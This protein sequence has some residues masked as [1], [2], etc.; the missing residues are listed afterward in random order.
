MN[1]WPCG[2]QHNHDTISFPGQLLEYVL[3]LRI[4]DEKHEENINGS[5]ESQST[6]CP[7]YSFTFSS[8]NN[9]GLFG[10]YLLACFIVSWLYI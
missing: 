3:V 1:R 5:I 10:H 6:L 8:L 7:F 4:K 9:Y 2:Q